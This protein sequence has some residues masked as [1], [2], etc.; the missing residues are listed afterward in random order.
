MGGYTGSYIST[1][2]RLDFSN[3]TV[4]QPGKNL[5]TATGSHTSVTGGASL[6]KPN[7]SSGYFAGGFTTG[8]V[9]SI[10][11]LSF[12]NDTVSASGTPLSQS[13]ESLSA[14]SSNEYGYFAGGV[15]A[16]SPAIVRSSSLDRIDY[17]NDTRIT[18]TAPQ[19]QR[20]SAGATSSSSYGYFGGGGA[21]PEPTTLSNFARLDF[22]SNTVSNPSNNLPSA[23]TS[24]DATSSSS[25]GYYVGG[26]ISTINR[27][28]FSNETVS[29]PGKNLPSARSAIAATSNN[30][31]GYFGGGST[32]TLIN[33]ITRLDFSTET[34][35][36]PGN[37][38]PSARSN[39]AAT[40]SNLYGYFGGGQTPTLISNISRLDFS[41]EGLTNTTNLPS[42]INGLSATKNSN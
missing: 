26:G 16:T 21:N 13:T 27:L 38:L 3:E 9:S 12:S 24:L 36:D 1:V 40:S 29:Q 7:R 25:Y 2:N 5:P 31:Y 14:V 19:L 32:P 15:T 22:S 18:S 11:K 35:S 28:D 41:T 30:F 23:I 34:V 17:L 37:N 33:T 39:F 6:L 20:N 42:A 8:Y 10:V 4:S